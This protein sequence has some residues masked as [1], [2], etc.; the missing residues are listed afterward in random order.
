MMSNIKLENISREELER[1]K[2][3]S[4][5]KLQTTIIDQNQKAVLRQKALNKPLAPRLRVKL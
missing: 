1:R 4:S 3:L 5:L 2:S